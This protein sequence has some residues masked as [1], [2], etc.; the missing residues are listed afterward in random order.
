[1]EN[2]IDRGI[3][4]S[5]ILCVYNELLEGIECFDFF[6]VEFAFDDAFEKD[7]FVESDAKVVSTEKDSCLS[8]NLDCGYVVKSIVSRL[9]NLK[10]IFSLDI[11]N[12][13]SIVLNLI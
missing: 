10:Q 5:T 3:F 9:F 12:W 2:F 13:L 7:K 11:S 4:L 8:L 1:M 6:F